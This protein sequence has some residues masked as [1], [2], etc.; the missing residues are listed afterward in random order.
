[1][2]LLKTAAGDDQIEIKTTPETAPLIRKAILPCGE[3]QA[4]R[5]NSTPTIST[6]VLN[7]IPYPTSGPGGPSLTSRK[8]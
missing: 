6:V 1:M 2:R 4:S 3:A 7:A 5:G 8:H